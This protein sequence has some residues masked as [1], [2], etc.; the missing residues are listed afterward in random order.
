MGSEVRPV[1]SKRVWGPRGLP[2]RTGGTKLNSAEV[3]AESAVFGTGQNDS[4]LQRNRVIEE[5]LHLVNYVVVRFRHTKVPVD[6]LINIGAIGL[7]KAVDSFNPD[8]NVKLSTYAAR[9]IKNEILM[10]LRKAGNIRFE[11][12]LEQP[13]GPDSEGNARVLADTV[14]TEFNAAE[15][16]EREYERV[17]V[18][19]AVSGLGEWER[20]I[21]E[22][23]F[24]IGGRKRLTQQDLSEKLGLSQS[25]ISRMEK[26]IAKELRSTLQHLEGDHPFS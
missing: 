6:E 15:N 4:L 17:Q 8:R 1:S 25:Y 2:G 26:R 9:C 16:L 23:R 18:A 7:I 24:A 20:L 14:G 10:H 13:I 22:S 11:I 5:N 3:G 12:S 21:V 19:E